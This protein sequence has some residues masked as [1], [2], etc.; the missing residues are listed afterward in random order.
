MA[1][2]NEHSVIIRVIDQASKAI[3]GIEKSVDGM[4]Q[5]IER[6]REWIQTIGVTA[7]VAFA[8]LSFGVKNAVG[9]FADFEEKMSGVQA[10]LNPTTEEMKK[11]TVQAE[12]L[13]AST[14]FSALETADATEVL[15]KNGLNAT[16]ILNWA[17]E[18]TLD[19]AAATGTDIATAADIATDAM[20]SF[21]LK[22]KELWQVMNSI[23]GVT[24]VSKFAIEDY[25]YALAAGGGVASA[26][27]VELEDFNAVIAAT[28]NRFAGGSDAGTSFKTFMQRLVPQSKEA[29]RAMQ[30]LWLATETWKSLFYDA[31]WKLKSMAEISEMLKN[32]T[33]NLS[34]EQKNQY[35]TMIFGSDALRTAS[36]LAE[37][38]AEKFK[39]LSAAIEWTNASENAKIRMNNLKGTFEELGGAVDSVKIAL[40]RA[41]APVIREATIWVTNLAQKIGEWSAENPQLVNTIIMIATSITGLIASTS[42][43]SLALW[44]IIAWLKLL[45]A[46]IGGLLSPV[47]LVIGAIVALGVAYTTNFLGFKDIIDSVV[48]WIMEKFTVFAG[49]FVEVWNTYWPPFLETVMLFWDTIKVVFE[50]IFIVISETFQTFLDNLKFAWEI[51]WPWILELIRFLWET[52]KAI[53]ST[54]FGV[55]KSVVDAGLKAIKWIFNIFAGVLTGD[56][57]RVWEWIKGIVTG[58]LGWMVNFIKEI[59]SG[60]MKWIWWVFGIDL[61]WAFSDVWNKVTDT[62]TGIVTG[63]VDKVMW[64]LNG[65]KNFIGWIVGAITGAWE[66]ANRVQANV[67]AHNTSSGTSA[68]AS[69]GSVFAGSRYMVGERWPELFIP[70]TSWYIVPNNQIWNN[71]TINI[72]MGGVIVQNEADEN[73]LA[74]KI[75]QKLRKEAKLYK[76][77]IA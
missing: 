2:K 77:W 37:V 44:P 50:T 30:E 7:G 19:L 36:G 70:N 64:I 1:S 43:L 72:N 66:E 3:K 56:W 39:E 69:G 46:I 67:R 22:T 40:G 48:G 57:G 18:A 38:G 13:G 24:N 68:R 61:L 27:G 26:L 62:V 14:K 23:T 17:L 35:L 60:I 29:T 15:A 32:A 10:V 6:H 33:K 5:H 49:F 71:A 9:T 54:A 53:F 4:L 75:S 20:A 34:E 16:Q 74:E 63:M 45:G 59:L 58:I 73:R 12:K 31:S 51:F 8:G 41:L 47:G 25:K 55:I 65:I 28:S 76:L 21:W 52:I 42:G 11:L